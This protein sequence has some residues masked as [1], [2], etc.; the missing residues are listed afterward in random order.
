MSEALR[1]DPDRVI[2][3]ILARGGSRGIPRKNLKTLAGV[4]LIGRAVQMLGD[5]DRI[6][7][8][9][10]STDDKEI[11]SMALAYGAE[12]PFLRP[13]ELATDDATSMAALEHAARELVAAGETAGVT[14][15]FQAT[16]PCCDTE[17]VEEALQL[18][19]QSD[20]RYLKSVTE[21]REH[22]DWMGRIEEGRLRFLSPPETTAKRRQDLPT[23]YRLNGAISIYETERLLAGTAE[24]GDP[25]AYVMDRE[26]SIDLDDL[27]DWATAENLLS[28]KGVLSR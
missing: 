19:V 9:V 15:L 21:V 2:A 12:I 6:P 18:F 23:L 8:V 22:P 4:P 24:T 17:Q 13:E 16:S 10:V 20:A 27:N 25:A 11:A 26:T 3:V 5:I 1:F 7:R 28:R 14:L